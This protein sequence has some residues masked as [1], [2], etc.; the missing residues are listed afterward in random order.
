MGATLL[1]AV[2]RLR[3]SP[4]VVLAILFAAAIGALAQ[5]TGATK[6]LIAVVRPQPADPRGELAKLGVPFT[7]AAMAKAAADGDARAVG[8]LLDAGMAVDA[9]ADDGQP[10]LVVA[11]RNGRLDVARR[12][13][14]AGADPAQVSGGGSAL[15]YA[16]QYRHPE[17]VKLFL[18]QKLPEPAIA[19]AL[20][21][22]AESGDLASIALLAPRLADRSAAA[23]RALQAVVHQMEN[24]RSTATLAAL[25]PLKPN[26][27]ALDGNQQTPLH[28]AVSFDVG[29]VLTALLR[30]GADPRV[31]GRC[32][33]APDDPMVTPLACAVVRGSLTG[34]ASVNALV[35]AR[36]D[37]DARGPGGTT[38]M[39][40][41]AGNGDAAVT[42]ALLAAGADPRAAD[43]KH[44]TALDYARTARFNDAEATVAALTRALGKPGSSVAVAR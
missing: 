35:A 19:D 14:D 9:A 37:V 5:F 13:R 8:L 2:E 23:T 44:R 11:A 39:M 38:P 27:N 41:A 10:P 6:T 22:A 4:W 18:E 15:D 1:A 3:K 16:A 21:F 31:T 42:A 32:D 7:P 17:V 33:G 40:L 26:L 34:L 20:A 36:A 29:E 28:V 25:L 43:D 30:A 12:L 24:P